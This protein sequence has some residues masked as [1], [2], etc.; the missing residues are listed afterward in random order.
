MTTP[1]ANQK[2]KGDRLARKVEVL[3]AKI[4]K[5]SDPLYNLNARD[6]ELRYEKLKTYRAEVIRGFVVYMHLAI[7]DLLT[8]LFFDFLVR[9]NRSLPE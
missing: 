8:A 7:E 4:D 1:I 3:K 2:T 6:P 5:L 9:L